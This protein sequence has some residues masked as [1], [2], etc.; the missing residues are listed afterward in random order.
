MKKIIFIVTLSVFILNFNISVLCDITITEKNITLTSDNNDVYFIKKN[1]DLY[2]LKDILLY[3]YN[4]NENIINSPEIIAFNVLH[5]AS[6]AS[7]DLVVDNHENLFEINIDADF[8]NQRK[9]LQ[10]YNYFFIKNITKP[11][12]LLARF[13]LKSNN[14]ENKIME[15]VLMAS[16]IT[17]T[18]GGYY[19]LKNDGSLWL[20][21]FFALLGWASGD[22]YFCPKTPCKVMDDVKYI[23]NEVIIK[24]DGSKWKL[25]LNLPEE[26]LSYEHEVFDCPYVPVK[27]EEY[28]D[29][30]NNKYTGSGVINKK[31]ELWINGEKILDNVAFACNQ[32]IDYTQMRSYSYAAIK[33]NGELWTWGNNQYGQLGDG[34]TTDR[35]IPKKVMDDVVLATC[36]N[37]CIL[38]LKSDGTL[39]KMG[40]SESLNLECEK[41]M[42]KEKYYLP[43]KI[44]DGVMIP[45]V[46]KRFENGWLDESKEIS[47]NSENITS[48]N[49]FLSDLYRLINFLKCVQEKLV[50]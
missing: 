31:D 35:K 14:E 48:K 16:Y 20:W 19:I 27:D 5:I 17:N 24:N 9:Y 41:G 45:T 22:P 15:D 18:M 11:H 6:V 43:H 37:S 30:E 25:A 29:Y 13:Y 2:F 34:T 23:S 42:S 7:K 50:F 49:E 12:F 4:Y 3:Y 8:I 44:E 39:W 26:E 1:G 21:G 33:T 32:N 40:Y 36:T 38:A 10:N 28:T 46:R 47:S